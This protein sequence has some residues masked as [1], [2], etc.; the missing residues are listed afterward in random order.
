MHHVFGISL[1][2]SMSA[3]VFGVRFA[4]KNGNSNDLLPIVAENVRTE[5]LQIENAALQKEVDTLLEWSGSALMVVSQNGII[6]LANA[7]ATMWLALPGTT[8]P[9]KTLLEAT[10]SDE[11]NSLFRSAS[12][13]KVV[14]DQEV[15]LSL[16]DL[17]LNVS[18]TALSEDS[19]R[20]KRFLIVMQNI[21]EIRRLETVRRDFVAN[22]S[23]ELRT[24][25]AS[26]RAMAETLQDGALMDA[27]VSNRFLGT[28][29]HETERLK[30]IAEDLLILADAESR[31]PERERFNLTPLIETTT[32]RYAQQAE[33]QGL[34]IR[35]ELERELFIHANHD[36][37]EQVVVNLVDNAVKYTSSGGQVNVWAGKTED[38]VVFKVID[39]GI[40]IMSADKGRIFERFYRVDKGR[41]RASGGTGLGLSI[42]KHIVDSH[43]GSVTVES[44]FN[45][46]STFTVSIPLLKENENEFD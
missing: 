18:I 11:L 12:E 34:I 28:I 26:I 2:A 38:S 27:G 17:V 25:L 44:E 39:T 13:G 42:V 9:G 10:F 19:V 6:E 3:S 4:R 5:L 21:T 1:F 45:H 40:G 24:P 37:I 23:H 35:N 22:V 36:Q 32:N 14:R 31:L 16:T 8:L 46:G 30:R 20:G 33:K 29:V 7:S 15:R 41:S 43:N